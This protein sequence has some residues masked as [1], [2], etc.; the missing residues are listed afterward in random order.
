MTLCQSDVCSGISSKTFPCFCV[1]RSGPVHEAVA[2]G[3]VAWW[4]DAR[5]SGYS[6]RNLLESSLALWFYFFV[7]IP[8]NVGF[9]K[10]K[11]VGFESNNSMLP[12]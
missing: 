6:L 4:M 5:P 10:Q 7:Q 11:G 1:F 9:K 12:I 2:L 3:T 8:E